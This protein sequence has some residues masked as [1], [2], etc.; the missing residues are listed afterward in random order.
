MKD[1]KYD[2][3]YNATRDRLRSIFMSAGTS[4]S[5]IVPL[6]IFPGQGSEFDRE[7]CRRQ[8]RAGKCDRWWV[9]ILDR[10][11]PYSSSGI[12]RIIARAIGRSSLI[13]DLVLL[14]SFNRDQPTLDRLNS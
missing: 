7:A 4:S 12:D 10:P 9:S 11:H 3:L 13:H 8:S 2:F 1:P 6:A 14:Q 5:G